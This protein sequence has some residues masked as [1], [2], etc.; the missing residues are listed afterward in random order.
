[1][2]ALRKKKEQRREKKRDIKGE[3]K[4]NLQPSSY[5]SAHWHN[6]TGGWEKVIE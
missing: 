4:V 3:K 6:S 5:F 2:A 1:M